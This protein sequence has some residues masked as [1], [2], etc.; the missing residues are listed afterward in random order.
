MSTNENTAQLFRDVVRLFVRDQ[1]ENAGCMDGGQT[2]RCHILNEL[3]RETPL[4]QQALV[5]RLGLDK[6]WISRAVDGLC[7]EGCLSKEPSQR[8]RRSVMLSLTA[9]GKA[10]AASLN[11]QLN[12][13]VEGLLADVPPAQRA[14][15]RNALQTL[16]A[17]LSAPDERSRVKCQK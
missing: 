12:Q 14:A 6:A 2:V 10:R 8:D 4:P 16:H 5:N 1:R 13:H 15:L 3:L 7:M 11:L 17:A 9:K